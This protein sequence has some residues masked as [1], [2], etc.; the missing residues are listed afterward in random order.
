[1]ISFSISK[2]ISCVLPS[3]NKSSR[4]IHA[5]AWHAGQQASARELFFDERT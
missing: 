3:G 2:K 5:Y 4:Q 1:M